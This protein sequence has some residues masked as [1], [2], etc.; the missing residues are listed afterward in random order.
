MVGIL[1]KYKRRHSPNIDTN[2]VPLEDR[3]GYQNE[4]ISDVAKRD[5]LSSEVF[6]DRN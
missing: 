4:F 6:A 3:V 1:Q 5:V 2:I